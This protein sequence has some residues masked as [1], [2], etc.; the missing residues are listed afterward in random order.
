M[1]HN[2]RKAVF[3]V[4]G[5]GTRLLPASKAI[6]K[7]M[8]TV[9]DRP[10]IQYAIEEARSAGIEE[11]IFV[12][13]RGKASI[14]DHFDVDVALEAELRSKG[15][16]DA[17]EDVASTEL[18]TGSFTCIRQGRPLGLGHAVWCAKAL[19]GNEPFAV[20]LPD[21]VF[22]SDKPVLQQ[23][24]EA[25]DRVGG[26]M[27]AVVEVPREK[28]NKYGILDIGDDDGTIAT[29]KGM[30]EKPNPADAPSTLSVVGRYILQPEVMTALDDQE[31]GKGGEIQLTDA[32]ARAIGHQK[33]VGFRYEGERFDCGDKAG[34]VMANLAFGLRNKDVGPSLKK[35]I[36]QLS[37]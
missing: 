34:F 1:A 3:P 16:D 30:V 20:V 32:I 2:V 26:N 37:R 27:L 31:P 17:L 6:P 36:A 7:E 28:T 19:V 25:Y 33:V 13:C 21:D 29:V 11:F 12:T 10:V 15:K 4:A 8:A 24:T 18:P 23:M 35:M 22:L 9:V 5:L 14:E